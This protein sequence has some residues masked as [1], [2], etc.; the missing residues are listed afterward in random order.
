MFPTSSA[1]QHGL[2]KRWYRTTE[3]HGVM[4]QKTSACSCTFSKT[5]SQCLL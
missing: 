2:L 3:L 5:R 1:W 4:T